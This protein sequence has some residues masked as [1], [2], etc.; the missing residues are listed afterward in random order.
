[1]SYS[2]IW[3]LI[4]LGAFLGLE[5][6]MLAPVINKQDV[7]LLWEI[8]GMLAPVINKQDVFLLWEIQGYGFHY[9]TTSAVQWQVQTN[10]K[11]NLNE[12][13]M[14][15]VAMPLSHLV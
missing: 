11:H 7:F 4:S 10:I 14:N 13:M 3:V 8:Q 6:T 2:R 5:N 1:M 12:A 9:R 15:N